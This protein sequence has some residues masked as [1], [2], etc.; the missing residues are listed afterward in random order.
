MA[1]LRKNMLYADCRADGLVPRIYADLVHGTEVDQKLYLDDL[2]IG[3]SDVVTGVD[4][5]DGFPCLFVLSEDRI[6]Y[7]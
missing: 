6:R 5:V 1:V 2:Y 7:V 3:S 4:T